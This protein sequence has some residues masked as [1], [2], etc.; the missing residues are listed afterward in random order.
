[1]TVDFAGGDEWRTWSKEDKRLFIERLRAR[2]ADADERPYY[3]LARP[4]QLPP[5][6]PRHHLPD[7]NGFS[8]GCG[9][10]DDDWVIY[11]IMAGRGLGKTWTGSNWLVAQALKHPK[12]EWGVFAPTFGDVRKVCIEGTSGIRAALRDGEEKQYRR[13]ELQIVLSNDSVIYGYSAD[14]PERVRGANLSGAWC[15]EIGSW[16]YYETWYEGLVP[17]LR[18]GDKP[19]VLATTTPRPT[20]LLRDLMGRGDGTVHVT[21]GSTWENAAN[22]SGTALAELKRRYEGTRLGRQELEGELLE[23]IEGALWSRSMID[24]ARVRQDEV[25][26]LLRVVV[27]VDPAV[28]GSETSDETGIVVVGE[29]L[30]GHAYVVADYSVKGSPDTAM[31]R[32]VA[33]YREHQAD[34]LVA[35]VNQGGDYIGTLLRTVDPN[36]PYR[37]VRATRNK[38]VRAEPVAAL[39]EQRR[40]H[41]VGV[42]AELEDQMVTWLPGSRQSPDR[43]DAL[44]WACSELRGLGTGDWHEA[45]GI[46]ICE[47]CDHRFMGELHPHVC[48]RCRT[49]WTE[50]DP[51]PAPQQQPVDEGNVSYDG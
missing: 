11:L 33:A 28:T 46:V 40:V 4:K 17:A 42:F 35:E 21:R 26:Q 18:I 5:D 50:P 39:Y 44:V 23:D 10:V 1:M 9:G 30:E 38:Q 47:G 3:Q 48:P 2:A 8:C 32:A 45:Y 43:A 13:N 36:I 37:Q 41:H 51:P 34:C 6:H 22:L 29:S 15:D 16:R 27:G 24:E 25:P 31:R 19:R 14:Q 20:K 49:R 12:T 7:A